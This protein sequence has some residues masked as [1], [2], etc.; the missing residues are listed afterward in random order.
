MPN[1]CYSN[2]TF[3]SHKKQDI[4]TMRD[5]LIKVY[6]D[7]GW[8]GSYVNKF[9]P[10]IDSDTIHCRGF[11]TSIDDEVRKVEDY[12]FF[13]LETET[14]WSPM[15]AIWRGILEAC[16]PSVKLAYIAEESGMEVYEKWDETHL[17]YPEKFRVSG[18]VPTKDGDELYLDEDE[19]SLSL[20]FQTTKAWL[21]EILPFEF[22]LTEG[23]D[24]L[25]EKLQEYIKENPSLYDDFWITFA[26]FKE[27]SPD[28][29]EL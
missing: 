23:G 19:R 17:F 4:A 14:A 6:N 18:Y 1:W 2:I 10:A 28:E 11:V 25:D 13:S 8:M 5:E 27:R 3:Y 7:D 24:N 16:F 15:I 9:L 22:E 20:D 29:F 12:Y 26:V 21:Q